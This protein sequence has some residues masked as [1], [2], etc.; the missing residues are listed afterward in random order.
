MSGPDPADGLAHLHPSVRQAAALSG[1]ERAH[2]I[3][4]DRWIGYP[5]SL[6][7]VA[8]L[9]EFLTWPTRQR[10]PDMLLA[11]PTN[12]GK[13]VIIER[14]RRNHLPETGPEGHVPVLCVQMPPDPSLPAFYAGVLAGLG[15]PAS[16]WMPRGGLE[17]EVLRRMRAAGVRMLVI[18]ELHNVLA[19]NGDTRRRFSNMLRFLGNE[20]RIPLVGVGTRE[21]Y[22]VVRADPQLENRFEPFVLPVWEPG[23]QARSLL[24][25]FA[26]S[27][28]L[29]R[30]PQIAGADTLE[31]VLTRTEGTIGEI[32]ALLTAAAVAAIDSG[33]ESLQ[34]RTLAMANYRGPS[35]RRRVFE[36]D[37]H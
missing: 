36:R 11:G 8:R 10:M 20:L 1:P 15:T 23:E 12:N 27:F 13:S 3:R 4:A 28:P 25:S 34:G 5:R 32:A 14:F 35:E 6:E 17:Q 22:L 37:L 26:A 18:D 16:V 19:G 31:Y 33:I 21:A 2:R 9:E 24:A 30:P 29:R 7:A